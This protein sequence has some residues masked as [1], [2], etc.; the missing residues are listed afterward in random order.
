MPFALMGQSYNIRFVKTAEGAA[1]LHG[2]DTP[3]YHIPYANRISFDDAVSSSHSGQG[4]FNVL[5]YGAVGDGTT[6]DRDAIQTTVT[7]A[8]DS[9][10]II[11]P[12]GTYKVINATGAGATPVIQRADAVSNNTLYPITISANNVTL[13]I[14]GRLIAT[15][16]LENLINTT[17]DNCKVIGQGGSMQGC[18]S[19][20]DTNSENPTLQWNPSLINFTGD[21]GEVS[22]LTIYDPPTHGIRGLSVIGMNVH[23]NFIFGGDTEHRAGT[24]LFGISFQGPA[25]YCIA[26]S[27]IIDQSATS[28]MVYSAIYGY[29]NHLN[30]SDNIIRNTLEHGVYLEG[31]DNNVSTNII[32][33][34]NMIASHIQVFGNRSN[35][36]GNNT[37][38]GKAGIDLQKGR[39]SKVSDNI[40]YNVRQQGIAYRTFGGDTDTVTNLTITNNI[41]SFNDTST[42]KQG[43]IDIQTTYNLNNLNVTGNSIENSGPANSEN[44]AGIFVSAAA[45]QMVSNSI[46]ANNIV[47]NSDCY[48]MYLYRLRNTKI[49]GNRV[50]NSNKLSTVGQKSSLYADYLLNCSLSDNFM[51][52]NASVN[53]D[54]HFYLQDYCDSVS[55]YGNYL[56]PFTSSAVRYDGTNLRGM[57]NE[58]G[59]M[60]LKPI[61][62]PPTVAKEGT[63]YMDT[64]HHLYIYNGTTWIQ[65]DN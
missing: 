48:G 55:V 51:T 24:T 18:G 2:V 9:S 59:F 29:G 28:G 44:Y 30:I 11:I 14:K 33:G 40:I 34:T 19:F 5:D 56:F 47:R 52:T 13:I 3:N 65:L 58:L 6:N 46:I 38:Q 62:I 54:Q 63:I 43:G 21:Y 25:S 23:D 20:L 53:I 8:G 61:A 32:V 27:N 37:S 64:D 35:I 49:S 41:I 4:I 42:I 50:I 16:L 60:Y 10:I 26:T 31:D 22:G 17:G 57:E 7:A 12:S 39:N 15:S 45:T 36:I 1:I